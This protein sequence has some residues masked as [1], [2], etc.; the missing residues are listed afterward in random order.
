MHLLLFTSSQQ[1]NEFQVILQTIM[2]SN[3]SC[4]SLSKQMHHTG[5][6]GAGEYVGPN[7]GRPITSELHLARKCKRW[8]RYSYDQPKETPLNL[9]DDSG[10]WIRCGGPAYE[11]SVLSFGYPS[12]WSLH[13]TG[14]R[15][16]K[17][18]QWILKYLNNLDSLIPGGNSSC[19]I[20]LNLPF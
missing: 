16:D 3:V 15:H 11:A 8:E 1:A 18:S 12:C 4:V 19:N 2:L 5:L 14:P 17:L 20:S 7:P 6:K 13:I 10:W 9:P